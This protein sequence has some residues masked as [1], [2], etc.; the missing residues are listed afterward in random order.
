MDK[1]A[2]TSI[3][4]GLYI[5]SST[6]SDGKYVGCI[7][8]TF[9]QI[10]SEPP[11]VSVALNK[12]N[13]TTKCIRKTGKYCA[14]VLSESANMELV[15][16]FGF[17]SSKDTDKF[18]SVNFKT[19]EVGLP[20][21]IQNTCAVFHIDVVQEVEVATHVL[22][23]GEVKDAQIVSDET[24]MTYNYYHTVL[25]GKTPPKAASYNGGEDVGS[26][27]IA[28]SI[29]SV[30]DA[31]YDANSGDAMSKAATST[32]DENGTSGKI[33]W[34]CSLCGYIVEADELPD[35]FMC[36]I[37]GAGKEFFERI[38]LD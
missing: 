13:H 18:D 34:R 23:I 31:G 2:F 15:G 30:G 20:I 29:S 27:E 4:Y 24:P 36:P 28:K 33:G 26:G 21:V 11:M 12:D 17:H 32:Q 7:A 5:I 3:N 14:S 19:N 10:A 38:T 35:D 22:F 1:K 6:D 8:N 9:Q 25:R 16:K 37:C